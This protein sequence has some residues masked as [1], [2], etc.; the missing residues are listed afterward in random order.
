MYKK[1]TVVAREGNESMMVEADTIAEKVTRYFKAKTR[2][3]DKVD[4]KS[5]RA[6][7]HTLLSFSNLESTEDLVDFWDGGKSGSAEVK[8]YRVDSRLACLVP[9]VGVYAD[10]TRRLICEDMMRHIVVD[11]KLILSPNRFEEEQT[12][13]FAQ[14]NGVNPSWVTMDTVVQHGAFDASK[15]MRDGDLVYGDAFYADALP[16]DVPVVGEFYK[17]YVAHEDWDMV[18]DIF[19]QKMVRSITEKS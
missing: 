1:E 11:E 2:Y 3:K 17:D 16:P 8:R 18:L 4:G 14:F 5:I 6:I 7:V 13:L 12:A 19:I 9:P 15:V 10:V